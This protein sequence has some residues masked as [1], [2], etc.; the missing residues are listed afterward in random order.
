MIFRPLSKEEYERLSLE[1][2]ADYL[3]RLMDD[4]RAR[5]TD[6]Q[7]AIDSRKPSASES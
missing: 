1:Q 3:R 6:T 7:R 2:K 4:I 5:M